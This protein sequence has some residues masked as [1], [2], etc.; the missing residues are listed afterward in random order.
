MKVG[1]QRTEEFNKGKSR[2]KIIYCICPDQ[3]WL[4]LSQRESLFTHVLNKCCTNHKV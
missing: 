2:K 4:I 1:F 3:E